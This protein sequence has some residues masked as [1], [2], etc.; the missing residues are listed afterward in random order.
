MFFWKKKKNLNSCIVSDMFLPFFILTVSGRDRIAA[1]A[2]R[3]VTIEQTEPI[4]K[5]PNLDSKSTAGYI[6]SCMYVYMC[7]CKQKKKR[8]QEHNSKRVYSYA[9]LCMC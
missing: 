6:H 5:G 2:P 1:A 4:F 3:Q 7:V 8:G 9:Y